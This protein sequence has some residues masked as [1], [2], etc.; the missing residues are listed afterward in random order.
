MNSLFKEQRFIQAVP[1]NNPRSPITSDWASAE[2]IAYT[3][4]N[5]MIDDS[6]DAFEPP[7]YMTFLMLIGS[8]SMVNFGGGGLFLDDRRVYMGC[9]NGTKFGVTDMQSGGDCEERETTSD[10]GDCDR[11]RGMA[12]I[13]AYVYCLLVDEGGNVIRVYRYAYDDLASGGTLMTA[14]LGANVSNIRMFCDGTNLYIN[15]DGGAT[16]NRNDL[17]KFSISGTTL[18]D[19]GKTTYGADEPAFGVACVDG[20]GNV[21]SFDNSDDLLLRRYN[22]AGTLQAT[23]VGVS[24]ASFGHIIVVEGIPYIGYYSSPC[25]YTRRLPLLP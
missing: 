5:T 6:M 12:K 13:G 17:A 19:E 14:T 21:Y 16:A 7:H 23:S 4:L 11:I 25:T 22:N 8:F 2:T 3:K 20:L 18:T 9:E 1:W 10:W 24:N 15:N